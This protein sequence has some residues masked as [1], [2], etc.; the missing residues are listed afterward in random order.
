MCR[1]PIYKATAAYGHFGRTEKSFTWEKTDRAAELADRLL[2]AKHKGTNGGGV[3]GK[4]GGS[5]K[6]AKKPAKK[7]RSASIEA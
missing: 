2:S 6:S 1:C 4:N 7:S 5:A 3:H